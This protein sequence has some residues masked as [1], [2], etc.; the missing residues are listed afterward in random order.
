[1]C[2]CVG[3][4]A[5]FVCVHCLFLCVY[6]V[7]LA[8]T[9][10]IGACVCTL[11]V[12][13]CMHCVFVFHMNVSLRVYWVCL[14]VYTCVLLCIQYV[15]LL[16]YYV[17]LCGYI[18][19]ACVSTLCMPLCVTMCFCLYILC[20]LVWEVL[21]FNL[22]TGNLGLK[23]P[24]GPGV[25][26]VEFQTIHW[27]TWAGRCWISSFVSS[28]GP[29]GGKCWVSIC[30]LAALGWKVLNFKFCFF[31]GALGWEVLNFN[32]FTGNLGLKLPWG[33]GVASVEFQT[34]HWQTWAGRCWISS[35]VSS[36]GPWGCK[37]W[38]SNYSLANLGW[39]VLNFK[40]CFFIG[41]LGW[42]VLSFN[43]FTGSLG[44]EGVE[45]QVLLL[46][47][48]ALGWEVLNFNLFTG[49]LRLE[50]HWGFVGASH[51]GGESNETTSTSAGV[52]QCGE[53]LLCQ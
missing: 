10:F 15:F 45:F 50:L 31:I 5:A 13:L 7:P 4:L 14:C 25:A 9:L 27:Q 52:S 33:P 40:F 19:C 44:L 53:C 51:G 47:W 32:L 39:K 36:L 42:E 41:A 24:W 2:V 20:A 17:C 22:F 16:V 43:L 11:C 34:I 23:L 30:S 21:N 29:W 28:L 38:V 37:C 6:T 18:G 49:S 48:G 12:L 26:S 46:H 1:M 3:T 35:F 8:C